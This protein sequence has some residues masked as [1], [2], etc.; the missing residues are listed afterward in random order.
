MSAR[1]LG[2]APLRESKMLRRALFTSLVASVVMILA[3]CSLP[4]IDQ[5]ADTMAKQLVT[6]I[7]EGRD[8][9]ANTSLASNLRN[10]DDLASLASVRGM[11]P[12]SAPTRIDN[13]SFNVNTTSSGGRIELLHAYHFADRILTAETVLLKPP[14]AQ[15]WQIAGF[16]MR[17]ESGT[18]TQ[19]TPRASPPPAE[20]VDQAG[21]S[22]AAEPPAPDRGGKDPAPAESGQEDYR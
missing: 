21:Q 17:H 16:H 13:R 10:P 22:G 12:N 19:P 6:D 4:V 18:Q 15:H 11:M 1:S 5:E 8:L 20:P 3:A 14:G 7:R 9:S 2:S